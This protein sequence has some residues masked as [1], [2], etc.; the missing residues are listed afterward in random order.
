MLDFPTDT[1]E[2][3]QSDS[4]ECEVIVSD[5]DGIF[6]FSLYLIPAN[7]QTFEMKET[8]WPMVSS[9]VSKSGYTINGAS[10]KD[11][12]NMVRTRSSSYNSV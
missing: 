12:L 1:K 9:V 4:L 6:T 11:L 7:T 5:S 3:R 2:A 10:T 8:K